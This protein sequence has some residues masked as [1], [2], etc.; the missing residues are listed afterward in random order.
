MSSNDGDISTRTREVIEKKTSERGRVKELERLTGLSASSWKNYLNGQQKATTAMVE[1]I[2]K[3][4]PEMAFWIATGAT[5]EWFGHIS[6]RWSSGF[7]AVSRAGLSSFKYFEETIRPNENKNLGRLAHGLEVLGE[8][9][10]IPVD[11]TNPIPKTERAAFLKTLRWLHIF[12]DEYLLHLHA[13]TA[14]LAFNEMRGEA[15][16]LHARANELN[17][18]QAYEELLSHFSEKKQELE[19]WIT[20]F[21]KEIE[22]K[23]PNK[24]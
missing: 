7:Y 17:E 15:K 9:E 1:C 5:D 16:A 11:R 2:S 8:M 6:P 10:L 24:V 19:N 21:N 20:K 4:Y 22:K 14:I 3:T 12:L 18:T 23:F 13:D